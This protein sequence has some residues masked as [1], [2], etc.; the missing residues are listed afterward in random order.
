MLSF[1]IGQRKSSFYSEWTDRQTEWPSH[2]V[3]YYNIDIEENMLLSEFIAYQNKNKNFCWNSKD[4][5]QKYLSRNSYLYF[6]NIYIYTY[7][8]R[9]LIYFL[10]C[11]HNG[12]VFFALWKNKIFLN[13]HPWCR[14]TL[15]SGN[16]KPVIVDGKR[17][18]IYFK[19]K[20]IIYIYMHQIHF[21]NKLY[22]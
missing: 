15:V 18:W 8:Y 16:Y 7:I 2:P 14:E 5:S 1:E 21:S 20:Y 10:N 11:I 19:E 6:N 4:M 12:G 22:S 17:S 13:W 9:C 3:P